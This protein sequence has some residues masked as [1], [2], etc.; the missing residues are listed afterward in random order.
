LDQSIEPPFLGSLRESPI[1]RRA[2][3]TL[4]EL[5]LVQA[6]GNAKDTYL[7]LLAAMGVSPLT[8][9]SLRTSETGSTEYA[10]SAEATRENAMTKAT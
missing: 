1:G 9:E 4:A 2:L 5:A 8:T 6:E 10:T 7:D 3:D